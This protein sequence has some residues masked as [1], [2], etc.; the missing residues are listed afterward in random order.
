M[1]GVQ[2]RLEDLSFE[3]SSDITDTE[4][5]YVQPGLFTIAIGDQGVK[6]RL[7]GDPLKEGDWTRLDLGYRE[8]E[9]PPS[10]TEQDMRA[11]LF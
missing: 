10:S 3:A 2:L 9:W 1:I 6:V 5:R 7:H 8:V 11:A 4:G